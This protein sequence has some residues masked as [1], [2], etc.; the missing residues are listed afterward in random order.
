MSKH[1]KGICISDMGPSLVAVGY[2]KT[3]GR[4]ALYT[5]DH[6]EELA[7]LLARYI[8]LVK[9]DKKY[10]PSSYGVWAKKTD[11]ADQ[12]ILEGEALS[13]LKNYRESTK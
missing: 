8:A 3:D 12:R 11:I 6:A 13:V 2:E 1:V 10:K 9:E 4:K 5:T 7:K